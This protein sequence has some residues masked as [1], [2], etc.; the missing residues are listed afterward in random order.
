MAVYKNE[1]GEALLAN[2]GTDVSRKSTALKDLKND[3][4]ILLGKSGKMDR[5]EKSVKKT[6]ELQDQGYEVKQVGHSL[7]G[8]VAYETA[9]KTGTSAD[10]FSTGTSPLDKKQRANENI[11]SYRTK[12]DPIAM[13]TDKLGVKDNIVKQ[14]VDMNP[15][16]V[17]NFTEQ[18][19]SGKQMIIKF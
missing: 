12:N 7:G 9:K 2:R 4:M 8:R 13:N 14:V 10:V 1:K 11:S 18:S 6:K 16:T 3:A 17:S 5:V 15:H 19:G